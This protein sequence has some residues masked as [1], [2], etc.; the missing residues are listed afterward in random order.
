[1]RW[2]MEIYH[3]VKPQL[4]GS[5]RQKEAAQRV[6]EHLITNHPDYVTGRLNLEG[7]KAKTKLITI[8]LDRRTDPRYRP[9]LISKKRRAEA[10]PVGD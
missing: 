10:R 7:E 4:K 1:M 5:G 6:A 8:I 9:K 3:H 2:A